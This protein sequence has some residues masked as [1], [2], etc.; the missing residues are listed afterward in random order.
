MSHTVF[1]SGAEVAIWPE[2]SFPYEVA[3]DHPTLLKAAGSFPKDLIV[4]T[5][6]YESKGRTPP[7]LLYA[8]PGTPIH[9]TALLL[10]PDGGIGGA[11]HK[12]HLVPYGEYIPLKEVLPFVRKLTAQIGEFERGSGYVLLPS[13]PVQMGPL[14]CYEDIFPEIAR[15]HVRFGAN[16]L[17][18]V[19]NDA[20]YGDSSALVQHL[21]FSVFRAVE[22]RRSLVRSTNTGITATL[23]PLGR[24][25]KIL[26]PFQRDT[27]IDEVAIL[28][29]LSFYTKWGDV[30]A[31]FCMTFTIV[32]LGWGVLCR[33]N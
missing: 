19:S 1:L 22:N 18:N 24:V 26:P 11:Y 6:T 16:L 13:G 8:P 31:Y 12:Q 30:F 9:N 4:G 29:D 15:N 27:L 10:R 28:K 5:V 17:V 32:T 25:Q 7:E 20:W 33:K 14:V 21:N 23:D 2:S 3:L